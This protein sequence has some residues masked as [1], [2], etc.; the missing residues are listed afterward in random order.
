MFEETDIS[1][2]EG[3]RIG[4]AQDAAARTG[5]TVMICEGGA[6]AGV[7]ISGGGPASRETPLLSSNA[8]HNRIHAAVLSG[9][10]AFGLSAADGVMRYLEERGIGYDTGFAKVPLVVQSSLYD[11]GTGSAAIRPDADMGYAACLDSERD[12]LK[13]GALGAGT[14]A[15][16]GK[17]FGMERASRSGLGIA[18]LK[19]GELKMGAVVAVN[20][21]GDI[22]DF[23]TGEK[24][25][26]LKNESGNGFASC[27]EGLY[28]LLQPRD[29]FTGNTTIGCILTNAEFGRAEMNRLAAMARNGYARAIN[30]VGTLADGDSIYAMSF[31]R[32]KADLNVAGTLA[33]R[34][35]AMAIKNAVLSVKE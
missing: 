30:P 21:L 8:A 29:L 12:E 13:G 7:D 4:N 6:S 35:M 10:S 20:A 34:V 5:V 9:G 11:L 22:F 28:E 3:F 19:L 15:T 16:V 23:E 18:A 17:V 25:A 33:A 27:E 31:G 1:S 2:I 14:G 26:G 32:V 24:L